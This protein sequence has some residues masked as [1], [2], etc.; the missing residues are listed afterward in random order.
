[1]PSEQEEEAKKPEVEEHEVEP[2]VGEE[3]A[4]KEKGTLK[5]PKKKNKQ[6]D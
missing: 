3:D 2:L 1:M 4:V 5:A 6:G